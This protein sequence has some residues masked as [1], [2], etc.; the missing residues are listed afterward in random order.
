MKRLKNGLGLKTD[1]LEKKSDIKL[2]ALRN[3]ILKTGKKLLQKIIDLQNR[4][5]FFN[6]M[7]V[8]IIYIGFA[9]RVIGTYQK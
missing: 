9:G 2:M 4:N 7:K 8:R 5:W 6:N 3:W 1:T